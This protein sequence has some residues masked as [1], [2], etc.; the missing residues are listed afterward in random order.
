M[1][2]RKSRAPLFAFILTFTCATIGWS[3]LTLPDT[4]AQEAQPPPARRA[5]KGTKKKS[6][7]APLIKY[8]PIKSLNGYVSV[9]TLK[10]RASSQADSAIVAKLETNDYRSVEILEATP[11][12]LRVRAEGEESGKGALKTY[13]GWATWREVVPFSSAIVLDTETGRVVARMPLPDGTN[14]GYASFSPDGSHAILY[15]PFGETPCEVSTSDYKL[16]RC[17][18]VPKSVSV[19]SFFYGPTDDTLYAV[20]RLGQESPAAEKE[21]GTLNAP[22]SLVRVGET[23]ETAREL[24]GATTGFLLSR[25]GSTGFITHEKTGD[26]SMLEVFD[27][28]T[29]AIRN[30]IRLEAPYVITQPAEVIINRDGSV[31][32]STGEQCED[33][34]SQ[35][36]SLIDTRSG[37][38][39]GEVKIGTTDA[40]WYPDQNMVVG[41]ALFFRVW[42]AQEAQEHSV[43][44]GIWVNEKGVRTPAE[45]GIAYAVEAGGAR[46]GLDENGTQ[47]F[48][49]DEKNGIRERHQIPRPELDGQPEG[50]DSLGI[51]N[52][53]SSPDGK[54]LIIVMGQMDGC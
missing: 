21:G 49:L 2:L 10:L 33:G 54:R 42:D 16:T 6:A 3:S 39:V 26:A 41:D 23:A 13:E 36:L 8:G 31:L 19:E 52:I 35:M 32:Y 27:T 37:Q 40:G 5:P 28:V 45:E 17:L 46:F 50:I 22:L 44:K 38:S 51:Y 9:E 29:Q 25:D 14:L 7:P 43:A 53:L 4:S 20:A 11:D 15:T 34:E 12:F 1:R 30:I 48:K 18:D 47:L 24:S